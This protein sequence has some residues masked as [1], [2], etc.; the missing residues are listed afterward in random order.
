MEWENTKKKFECESTLPNGPV[1]GPKNTKDSQKIW[2]TFQLIFKILCI[3][4]PNTGP[5]SKVDLNRTNFFFVFSHS[6]VS[7]YSH[8]HGS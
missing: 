2:R 7:K 6:M 8:K 1:F 3:L 5:L 4:G